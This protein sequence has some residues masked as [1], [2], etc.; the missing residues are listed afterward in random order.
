MSSASTWRPAFFLR[1][2]NSLCCAMAKSA[3]S[4]VSTSATATTATS[5]KSGRQRAPRRPRNELPA[6]R[7]GHVGAAIVG[8]GAYL[9]PNVVSN[10]DLIAQY[11]VDTSDEWI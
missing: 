5:R 10:D 6:Q 3:P 9:P 4:N 8:T 2:R 11:G 1:T 7:G